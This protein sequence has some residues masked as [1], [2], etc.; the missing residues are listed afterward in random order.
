MQQKNKMNG[1]YKAGFIILMACIPLFIVAVIVAYLLDN[2]Y[3]SSVFSG[4]GAFL[5]FLGIIFVMKSKPKKINHIEE[6]SY[7]E[8]I[9]E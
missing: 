9:V 8:N 6:C 4:S 5:A 2:I 3:L 1:F 7:N